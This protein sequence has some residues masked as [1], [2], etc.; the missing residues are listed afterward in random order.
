MALKSTRPPPLA[1]SG[2]RSSVVPPARA[3][4]S[5]I[6]E[7]EKPRPKRR[8]E[9]RKPPPPDE[10]PRVP[11]RTALPA[12]RPAAKSQAR[13]PADSSDDVAKLA[14]VAELERALAHERRIGAALREVGLALGTTSELDRL[15][16]LILEKVNDA[17]DADR[18]TL[19][20]I[21]E[22]TGELVSRIAQGD[23]VR[24]IRLEAGR[25]IAGYVARVG[26]PLVVNDPYADERFNPEWDMLSGY[27]TRSILAVPM[28]NHV[29]RIIGVVQV[30]NKRT[31]AFVDADAVVLTAITTQAAIAIENSRLVGSI[32]QKNRELLE[33][34]EQLEHR[35]RDLKLLFDLESAMGRATSLEELFTGVLREALRTSDARAGAFAMKAMGTETAHLHLMRRESSRLVRAP[36]KPGSGLAFAAMTQ[37]EVVFANDV[38]K[39]DGRDEQI[40]ELIGEP[41]RACIAVPLEGEDGEAMGSIALYNKTTSPTKA[42]SE[43]DRALLLLIAAN[44]STAIRLQLSR[45]A[46]EREER[47]TTIGRLLSG[48]IHDL[49]T[50]L[51]VISGYVQL[52]QAADKRSVRD[53]YAELAL[54]Q[55]EHI[56]LMQRDVLEFARGEKS[57]L[58]RKVYLVKFFEDIKE[59]L[60]LQLARQGVEL[61]VDLQDRGTARFDE[62]KITRVVQN[63]A[64]NAAEAMAG[65]GGR[66]TIK[67]T[68]EKGEKGSGGEVLVLTFSDTGPGIPKEI[69]HRL[70]Q[71][72]VTSGKK[73]GT[74][75]GLAITK[76]IAEEH[77]GTISVQSSSKGV[78]FKLRIPQVEG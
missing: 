72:F 36:L 57:I 3:S 46:R 24:A 5:R 28:K 51:T 47:L 26:Q 15:L 11:A 37:G 69:E 27:R 52:M 32:Q 59:Q 19:Y 64:R 14:E 56:G 67:V 33:I 31:G 53:E 6:V 9:S 58:I 20:L 43:E 75:L 60:Q 76:R 7:E 10:A 8:S 77:G 22:A 45:E 42:F 66:F 25:G 4:A 1:P 39:L 54:K 61:V 30:L 71:S 35:V 44:A 23:Q 63:L 18:A 78:T 16:E 40:D 49:K 74:G 38:Q 41:C 13:L 12:P 21:D 70:F 65:R 2:G 17:V 55:F 48:V 29:G 68:R 62:G 34:K 73:G 50:P